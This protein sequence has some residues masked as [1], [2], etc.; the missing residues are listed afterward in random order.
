MFAAMILKYCLMTVSLR[1][2]LLLGSPADNVLMQC[3]TLHRN[4]VTSMGKIWRLS[5]DVYLGTAD[6]VLVETSHS[7]VPALPGTN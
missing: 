4:E 7:A 3:G 6:S 1:C 5:T 2:D